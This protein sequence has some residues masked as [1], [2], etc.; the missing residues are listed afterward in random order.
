MAT[1]PALRT[2][3]LPLRQ[4]QLS[5]ATDVQRLAGVKEVAAGTFL[6]HPYTD[7]TAEQWI[8]SQEQD[9]AAGTFVNFALGLVA[10]GS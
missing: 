8:L 1:F 7:G 9:F 4:F 10:N 5:D 6:P 3:R 2:D